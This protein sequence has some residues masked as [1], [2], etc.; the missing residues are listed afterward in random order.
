M[1]L[2]FRDLGFRD[3]GFG[4]SSLEFTDSRAKVGIIEG[5]IGLGF[6]CNAGV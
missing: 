5:Y 2:G 3:L 6:G 1:G 4:A